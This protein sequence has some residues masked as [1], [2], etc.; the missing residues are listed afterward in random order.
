[1]LEKP[2]TLNLQ[3]R[4]RTVGRYLAVSVINLANHQV[5]LFVANT[6]W[7]WSGGWSNVFAACVAAVPAYFLSRAWVWEVTGKHNLRQEVLPFWLLA[8]AGLIVSTGLAEAADRAMGSGLVVNVAS[9]VG[10]FLVWVAKFLLLD[11]MFT[12]E[13]R[14]P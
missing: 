8:L 9:L 1:M 4:Y 5:L 3:Q 12:T 7:G 6:V 13:V 10:Y 2:G 11:R 14:T